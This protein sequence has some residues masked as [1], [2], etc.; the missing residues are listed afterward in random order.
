MGHCDCSI[1]VVRA[2]VP[3]Y[4]YAIPQYAGMGLPS[5]SCR[6]LLY[7]VFYRHD[8]KKEVSSHYWRATFWNYI[9]AGNRARALCAVSAH[10]SCASIGMNETLVGR[11]VVSLTPLSPAWAARGSLVSSRTISERFV[12]ADFVTHLR[13]RGF[14]LSLASERSSPPRAISPL[15]RPCWARKKVHL[16]STL[17]RQ[18]SR[19][20]AGGNRG[21][22]HGLSRA[23]A[24]LAGGDRLPLHCQPRGDEN[25]AS[26]R[27]VSSAQQRPGNEPRLRLRFLFCPG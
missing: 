9:C 1:H 2:P 25:G 22:P 14:S 27:A 10:L 5:A 8:R 17:P 11:G 4:T 6:F 7:F 24:L 13:V 20:A 19:L 18:L 26:L 15:L 23:S 12:F 3:C 21:R 16:L